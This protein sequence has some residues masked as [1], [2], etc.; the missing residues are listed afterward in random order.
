MMKNTIISSSH[1]QVKSFLTKQFAPMLHAKRIESLVNGVAGIL[2]ANSL[3]L[4]KIGE[5]LAA[6]NGILPK[7]GIKQVDRYLS[8][9]A[10]NPYHLQCQLARFIIS[11]RKR[12]Y[13]A[14]DWTV[15]AKDSQMTL[16]VRLVTKHGR[17]TPLLWETVSTIGL[18]DNKVNYTFRL[19]ER[20]RGI[21]PTDCQ[22]I[23]LADREFGT[24]DNMIKL[25]EALEFDY[26]LRIKRNF[27]I[28]TTEGESRLAYEWYDCEQAATFDNPKVTLRFHTVEKVIVCKEKGMK[29]LWCLASSTKHLSTEGILKFYGA[30]WSTETSYRDEKDINFG[31]GLKKSHIR[32]TV[33]RDRLFLLSAIAIILLTLLGAASEKVGFDRYIKANTAKKR[34]HSLFTQGRI[35]LRLAATMSVLWWNKVQDAFYDLCLQTRNITSEQFVI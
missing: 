15:F 9:E 18:K 33:R 21:I 2:G 27:T 24:I 31:L 19:L 7:H 28:T 12:I 6:I 5:G 22:V 25:K 32:N 11:N 17:A 14:M 16:T 20:L 35:I 13:V 3:K 30:R 26:I 8:N 1:G 4:S 29:D 10:I 23:I 34:T